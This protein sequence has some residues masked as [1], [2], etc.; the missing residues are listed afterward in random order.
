[1]RVQ[2]P[3]HS[4][5]DSVSARWVRNHRWSNHHFLQ[6]GGQ[7]IATVQING[8]TGIARLRDNEYVLRRFRMPPCVTIRDAESN[9]MVARFCLLPAQGGLLA[10]FED[11]ESFK[12]GWVYFWKRV[13]AWTNDAGEI[14]LVSKRPRFRGR[15]ELEVVFPEKYGDKWPLLAILELAMAELAMPWFESLSS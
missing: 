9:D 4:T 2:L 1:L 15:S 10:E 5:C 12:F 14:V 13:W 8:S 6:C 11:G 7:T 3:R